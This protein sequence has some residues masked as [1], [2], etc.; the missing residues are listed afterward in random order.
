MK[1]VRFSS[2]CLISTPSEN[3]LLLEEE[4]ISRRE[5]DREAAVFEADLRMEIDFDE[6][7][8][9]LPD[10]QSDEMEP[11]AERTEQIE[12]MVSEFFDAEHRAIGFED[13]GDSG[14]VPPV[15]NEMEAE[16]L[17]GM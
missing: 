7:L 11:S 9:E 6:E 17:R 8:E 13:V 5:E 1:K 15:L 14:D 2:D 12:R 3:A 10:L 16:I 4:I